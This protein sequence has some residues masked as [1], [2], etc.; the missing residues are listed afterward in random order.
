M[1]GKKKIGELSV[2][3]SFPASAYN[4]HPWIMAKAETASLPPHIARALV[5][6]PNILSELFAQKAIPGPPLLNLS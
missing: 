1:F 6:H 4:S 3:F 5:I 2:L